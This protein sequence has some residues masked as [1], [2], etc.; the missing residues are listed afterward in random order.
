MN[1]IAHSSI[2]LKEI[3]SFKETNHPDILDEL[4]YSKSGKRRIRC[5]ICNWEP[6]GKPYWMCE[7]CFV[8]F[9]TFKTRAHCPNTECGNSWDKTQCIQCHE[10]SYHD[11]WYVDELN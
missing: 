3:S 6:D 7:K 11:N 1:I 10:L 9:D 4:L 2:I 5:P 8:T